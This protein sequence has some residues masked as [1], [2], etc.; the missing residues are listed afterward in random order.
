[1]QSLPF[2]KSDKARVA[3][4]LGTAV[5]AF[6]G[7]GILFGSTFHSVLPFILLSLTLGFVALIAAELAA[8]FRKGTEQGSGTI[9]S[10]AYVIS[11]LQDV[12]RRMGG[13]NSY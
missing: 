3:F 2:E 9:G 12:V 10:R 8:C 1:M 4:G 7:I 5:G 13:F 11:I 6:F